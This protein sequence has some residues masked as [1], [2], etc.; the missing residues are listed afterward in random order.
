MFFM[1]KVYAMLCCRVWERWCDNASSSS[2]IV[3]CLGSDILIY[4]F[5]SSALP[6]LEYYNLM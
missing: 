1:G 4:C 2:L 5:V 3:F 6:R